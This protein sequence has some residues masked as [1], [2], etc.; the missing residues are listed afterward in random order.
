MSHF[1]DFNAHKDFLN[2]AEIVT[3]TVCI[4]MLVFGKSN[5]SVFSI[6]IR[7]EHCNENKPNY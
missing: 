6:Q 5:F 2:S 3:A 1:H 4:D 7:I